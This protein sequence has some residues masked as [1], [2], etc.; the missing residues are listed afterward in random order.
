MEIMDTTQNNS[1]IHPSGNQ[2]N[3]AKP[4]FQSTTSIKYLE[5]L[6]QDVVSY[7]ILCLLE[8]NISFA[9]RKALSRQT[10][11]TPVSSVMGNSK[12]ALLCYRLGK[13]GYIMGE[14]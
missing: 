5:D 6:Y 13:K 2:Q 12:T 7:L 9:S 3:K 1:Y 8:L 14:M 10:E 4:F 11:K